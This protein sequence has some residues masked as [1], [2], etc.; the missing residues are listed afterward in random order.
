MNNR[1]RPSH[2][3]LTGKLKDA[4]EAVSKGHIETINQTVIAKDAHELGYL[5]E[6]L[7]EVLTELLEGL[8]PEHYS[9]Q[10]P[11]DRSYTKQI[12]GLDMFVFITY[13]ELLQNS[14]YLKFAI[15]DGRFWLVSLHRN[16]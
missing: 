3:E 2:K 5:I 12:Q 4:R 6:E 16:R 14:V 15:K 7:P 11:P 8:T 9:G 13:S 10:R 1:Y